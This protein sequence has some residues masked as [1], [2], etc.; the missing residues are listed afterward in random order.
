[1]TGIDAYLDGLTRSIAVESLN[2]SPMPADDQLRNW[3]AVTR[4]EKK[5]TMD[6]IKILRI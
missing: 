6:M 2:S 3:T 5:M 1:L 4:P